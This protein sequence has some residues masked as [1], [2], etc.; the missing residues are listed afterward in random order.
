MQPSLQTRV[1]AELI[2]QLYAQFWISVSSGAVAF[3]AVLIGFR[4]LVSIELLFTTL[5]FFCAAIALRILIYLRFRQRRPGHAD[6]LTRWGH[7]YTL[8]AGTSGLVWGITCVVLMST[9]SFPQQALLLFVLGGVTAGASQSLATWLRSLAA[10]VLLLDMPAVIWMLMQESAT[11]YALASLVLFFMCASFMLA[12]NQNRSFRDAFRLQYENQDLATGLKSEVT[13][14]KRSEESLRASNQILKLVATQPS[15]EMVL[16]AVNQMVEAQ[17]EPGAISSILMLDESRQHLIVASAPTAPKS[18]INNVNGLEIGPQAGCCGAAVYTNRLVIAEDIATSPMW[19]GYKELA[20]SQGLRSCFSMPI[21]GMQGE[22]EG[23][24]SVFHPYPK[25]PSEQDLDILETGAHLAG[26]V[27][28]RRR[29]EE[30]LRRMAHFDALTGLPNRV[31]F[32]DRLKQTLAWAKRSKRQFALLYIDLDKFKYINDTQGHIVGDKVLKEVAERLRLCV[33][34]VDTA[35]RLGGDEFTV[36]ITDTQD[37]HAPEVVA[38]KII[39]SLS[40][41]MHIEGKQYQIGASIGISM[42]PADSIDGEKLV[43]LAD[44]AMYQ[45]KRKGGNVSVSYI[46]LASAA[47]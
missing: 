5:V 4:G 6:G 18:Y 39:A 25:A 16:A 30:Q 12:R 35:A 36:L 34:D 13:I 31:L 23:A 20:L 3:L 22:A 27:F 47:A 38:G 43:G 40:E 44:E 19:E 15:S 17:L 9:S 29:T 2:K 26:I 10:F 46:T 1:S 45:A 28:E 7:W 24:L 14:R 37:Q 11:Q 8:G 21:R 32:L 41:P 42:Y 33:R